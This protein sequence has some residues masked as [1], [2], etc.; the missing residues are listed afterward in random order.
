MH[1]YKSEHD[2]YHHHLNLPVVENKTALQKILDHVQAKMRRIQNLDGEYKSINHGR[3]LALVTGQHQALFDLVV[4][5]KTFLQVERDIIEKAFNAG[6]N[7]MAA[8]EFE[9]HKEYN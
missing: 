3:D 1:L 5:L 2:L 6:V 4:E 9:S 8:C 7:Y